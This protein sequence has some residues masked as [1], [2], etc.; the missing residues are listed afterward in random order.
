MNQQQQTSDIEMNDFQLGDVLEL[1]RSE[2]YTSGLALNEQV[3]YVAPAT[4][5]SP[6]QPSSVIV[7]PLAKIKILTK[8]NLRHASLNHLHVSVARANLRKVDPSTYNLKPLVKFI[9]RLFPIGQRSE[10]RIEVSDF[11]ILQQRVALLESKVSALSSG[12]HVREQPVYRPNPIP[13]HMNPSFGFGGLG[14][15]SRFGPNYGSPSAFGGNPMGTY[16]PPLG[17][18]MVKMH[19]PY[20]PESPSPM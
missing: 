1:I 9:K 7:I 20:D 18:G 2:Q 13:S 5:L 14:S 17:S 10:P 15:S 6:N 16:D 11:E 8:D 4:L 3:I 12:L 19:A